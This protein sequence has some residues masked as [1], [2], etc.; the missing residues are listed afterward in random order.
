LNPRG[1]KRVLVLA[2]GVFAYLGFL[3]VA[4]AALGFL[5]GVGPVR[6][7]DAATPAPLPTA[8]AIDLGLIALF[9]VAHSVMARPAFK[10]RWILVTGEAAERSVYVL[11]ASAQLA[12]I[13]WQWR[14]LPQPLWTVA[15]PAGR[16]AVGAL[17]LVGVGLVIASSFLT[18][19]FDLFGLR[20]VWLFA[21]GRPYTPVPFKEHALYRVVRHPMMLGFLLSFWAAP[22]MSVGHALFAAGMSAYIPIG[23]L[24]EERALAR[25][26]GEPY[27]QYRRTVPAIIPSVWPSLALLLGKH[28]RRR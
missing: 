23:I 27:R 1:V 5:G 22:T 20:Q 8:L 2:F 7:I 26:L 4:L 13:F 3:A 11:V 16:T 15:S 25:T 19:H 24:F 12:L 9:G 10:R 17:A 14:A 6:G 28:G 21:S 18:D